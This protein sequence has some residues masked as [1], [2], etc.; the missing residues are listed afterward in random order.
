MGFLLGPGSLG[1]SRDLALARRRVTDGLLGS[2]AGEASRAGAGA[3]LL[4]WALVGSCVGLC[5]LAV[6][7]ANAREVSEGSCRLA[8]AGANAREVFDGGLM[9]ILVPI[10]IDLVPIGGGQGGRCP[11]R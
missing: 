9:G 10:G 11:A 6:A 2:G 1:R 4:V 5:R 7:S 3:I 8:V